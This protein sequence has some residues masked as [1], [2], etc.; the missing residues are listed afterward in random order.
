MTIEIIPVELEAPGDFAASCLPSEE[1]A[2]PEQ[3]LPEE[4]V[5]AE[6]EEA[7]AAGARKPSKLPK[8]VGSHKRPQDVQ[9]ILDKLIAPL[10]V[11]ETVFSRISSLSYELDG[12]R[13]PTLGE[14]VGMLYGSMSLN[15]LS[16][17]EWATAQ[18]WLDPSFDAGKSLPLLREFLAGSAHLPPHSHPPAVPLRGV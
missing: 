10:K 4:P 2:L 13:D 5:P 1:Q 3:A 17:L 6:E 18:P 15:A 7:A 14:M 9:C 11:G 12:N 16:W 8:V